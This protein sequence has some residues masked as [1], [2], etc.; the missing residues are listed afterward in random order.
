MVRFSTPDLADANPHVRALA[1]PLR[2]FGRRAA[3]SGP[4]VTIKCFEDNSRVK[5]TVAE[6]GEGRVI[7]VDGGGSLRCAL[8]GDM[9]AGAAADN[10]WAGVVIDGA[11]RDVDEIDAI[12]LGVQALGTSPIRSTRLGVGQRDIPIRIGGVDVAPGDFLYADR[13]GVIISAEPL[14]PVP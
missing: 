11:V 6:P 8:L 12:D 10:G 4:V 3:F 9:L 1:L 13:N 5:E 14:Q 7:V 2:C